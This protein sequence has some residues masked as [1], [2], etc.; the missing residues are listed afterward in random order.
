MELKELFSPFGTVLQVRF[1]LF[2]STKR[3]TG[4]AFVRFDSP[5]SADR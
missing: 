3:S 2:Q 5:Q 4:K 1:V